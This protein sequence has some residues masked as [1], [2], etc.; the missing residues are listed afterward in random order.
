MPQ[1]D[2]LSGCPSCAEPL[3]E[4]DLYCG[5]CGADLRAAARLPAGGATCDQGEQP[6]L[7]TDGALH[8][9]TASPAVDS[10]A[11]AAPP[12]PAAP[13]MPPQP[14][15]SPPTGAGTL[16]APP[17]PTAPS[18]PTLHLPR[19]AGQTLETPTSAAQA[20]G[21]APGAP[22]PP[23]Q[24][25]AA[26]Q[27]AGT[28]TGEPEALGPR[29]I[30][31]GTGGI[32]G[33]GCC[34]HCGHKQPDARDHMEQERGALA[35]AS[36][37]GLRHQRNQDFFAID[38]CP[39]SDGGAAGIAVVC[40]G[41][42]SAARSEE[43]SAAASEAARA[44]L[45]ESVPRGAHPED[46]MHDA[47][48]AAADAVSALASGSDTDAERNPPACTIVG[49]VT[50]AELL[51]IGWIGDSRAYWIPE[52][53]TSSPARLTEDDSW[54]AHMVAAGL[55]SEEEAQ[56]DPRA[57]AITGW[58]GADAYELEPHTASFTPRGPGV[59]VVCSDGLWNYAESATEMAATVPADARTRPLH[60]A[61]RLVGHALDSGGH[62]NVTVA[63]VP[64][65]VPTDGAGPA[66]GEV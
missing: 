53:R 57:H 9:P 36:D 56:A 1:L 59:V 6:T 25:G 41:V 17:V 65:P 28:P 7:P 44:A 5:A 66:A 26:P 30:A 45:R 21:D 38:T 24:P 22:D 33:D 58:L 37:R 40:D 63:L 35:A 15:L 13:P 47:L 43:A 20:A 29:C 16:P 52:D 54:A 42:S 48:L 8:S 19:P 62:D 4:G 14:P 51:T 23:P 50:T 2:R 11:A 10:P 27:P 31:C 34:E 3:E 32:D 64:F 18:T 46:A 12:P 60:S 61:Q 55:L 49:A 39:L